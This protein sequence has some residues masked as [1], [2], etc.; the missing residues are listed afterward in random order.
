M[1]RTVG[2]ALLST[3]VIGVALLA[4]G[5]WQAQRNLAARTAELSD[6]LASLTATQEAMLAQQRPPEIT[7]H[8]YL[9]DKSKPAANVLV[10]IYRFPDVAGNLTT[11]VIVD[12]VETDA[13]GHFKTGALQYG[14]YSVIAPL[15]VP[16]GESQ[17]SLYY[18]EIQSRPMT[19]VTG[20]GVTH[21]TLDVLASARVELVTQ[22]FPKTITCAKGQQLDVTTLDN[23]TFGSSVTDRPVRLFRDGLETH[24]TPILDW[25]AP[26]GPTGLGGTHVEPYSET[27]WLPPREY[28]VHKWLNLTGPSPDVMAREVTEGIEQPAPVPNKSTFYATL[29]MNVPKVR[30]AAGGST[31][32]TFALP[33]G[34]AD[35]FKDALPLAAQGYGTANGITYPAGSVGAVAQAMKIDV[36]V[37]PPTQTAP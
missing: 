3:L 11:G 18:R 17:E 28:E 29:S 31:K 25:P 24:L 4:A 22:P 15:Q 16:Q 6:Q 5:G 32:V 23:I 7:G 20:S 8:C 12:A 33:D 21:V 35:A 2:I 26:L 30:T 10:K 14:E 1:F 9:G 13:D 27:R 37:D 19:V 34:F 36:K